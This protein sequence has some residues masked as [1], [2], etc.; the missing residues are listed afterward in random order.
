MSPSEGQAGLMDAAWSHGGPSFAAV[1]AGPLPLNPP[2]SAMSP[3][4]IVTDSA[5]DLPPNMVEEHQLTVVPLTVRFG[6][7]D[8]TDLSPE[9][10]WAKC[11]TT[12]VL[13]ETAAPAPGAFAQAFRRLS[14]E[15]ADGIV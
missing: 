1:R 12:S 4:R 8:C 9:Q 5:C 7:E 3:I 6:S 14:A 2:R 15:G 11:K 13:P 10:F